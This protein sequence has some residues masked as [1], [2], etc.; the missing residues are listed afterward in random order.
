MKYTLDEYKQL[1]YAPEVSED[2]LAECILEL[3]TEIEYLN[4]K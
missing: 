4:S 1:A 3:V 2:I